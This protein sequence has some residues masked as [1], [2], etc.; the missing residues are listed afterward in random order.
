MIK[1]VA[2]KYVPTA[3]NHTHFWENQRP[4]VYARDVAD[5]CDIMTP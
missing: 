4:G 3:S 2:S 5:L 1:R